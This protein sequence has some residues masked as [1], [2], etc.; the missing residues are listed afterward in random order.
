MRCAMC[1]TTFT[2]HGHFSEKNGLMV[3][4]FR[5]EPLLRLLAVVD[6]A[7]RG[8]LCHQQPRNRFDFVSCGET[9][10]S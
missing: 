9:V 7:S 10:P 6:F 5:R 2:R 1:M 4:R 3:L 8:G